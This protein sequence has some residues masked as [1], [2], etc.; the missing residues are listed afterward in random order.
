MIEDVATATA[1]NS[2]DLATLRGKLDQ[3]SVATNRSCS[4][5]TAETEDSRESGSGNSV[6][7]QSAT[8][9]EVARE[10]SVGPTDKL[11]ILGLAHLTR[12]NRAASTAISLLSKRIIALEKYMSP[13]DGALTNATKVIADNFK[14]MN[15]R[16]GRLSRRERVLHRAVMDLLGHQNNITKQIGRAMS[17]K[18]NIIVG[19]LM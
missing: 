2:R 9:E 16:M 12:E 18:Q 8:V 15:I 17:Q 5:R 1:T 4:E 11:M 3:L 7:A 14:K 6:T 19:K 10:K 13:D